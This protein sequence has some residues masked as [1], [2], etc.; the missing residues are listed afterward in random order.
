MKVITKNNGLK[1]Y[2][3]GYPPL[4]AF[5][6]LNKLFEE[7]GYSIRSGKSRGTNSYYIEA[8]NADE[9]KCFDIRLSDHT[10]Y[11]SD[12]S[13]RSSM[14][15]MDENNLDADIVDKEGFLKVKKEIISFMKK[16]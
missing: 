9:T 3:T 1:V 2:Q 7:K 11:Q 10:K 4:F 12:D 14:Y 6:A 15:Y 16:K 13:T 8:W 5:N